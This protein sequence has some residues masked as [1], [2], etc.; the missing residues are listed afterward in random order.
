MTKNNRIHLVLV[1]NILLF[2][3][4]EGIVDTKKFYSEPNRQECLTFQK[5]RG[6]CLKTITNDE[7]AVLLVL[8]TDSMIYTY[9]IP[10]K[11]SFFVS[12]WREKII[13]IGILLDTATSVEYKSWI[14]MKN[15]TPDFIGEYR[16]KFKDVRFTS[17]SFAGNYKINS[18]RYNSSLFNL[19]LY[20][21]NGLEKTVEVEDVIICEDRLLMRSISYGSIVTTEFY[22]DEQI[23]TSL[24]EQLEG[25]DR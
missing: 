17:S 15:K 13:E 1:V 9:S 3:C 5:K 24:F 8:K 16:V 18:L 21:A 6:E 19:S 7:G 20:L 14:A 22:M 25:M 12:D 10:L 11:G 4:V 23:K 2:S